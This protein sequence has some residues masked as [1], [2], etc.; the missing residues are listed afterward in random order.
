MRSAIL[1]KNYPGN[2]YQR[3]GFRLV[4]TFF[5]DGAAVIGAYVRE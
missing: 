2:D 5:V 3:P 4:K 1:I